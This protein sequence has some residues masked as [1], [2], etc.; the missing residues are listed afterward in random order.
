[1][2]VK[3]YTI[4]CYWGTVGGNLASHL[5]LESNKSLSGLFALQTLLHIKVFVSDVWEHVD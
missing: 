5:K 3:N 2:I 1:M 4:L